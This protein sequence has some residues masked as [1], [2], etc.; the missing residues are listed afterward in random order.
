MQYP[1]QEPSAPTKAPNQDLK[2]MDALCT[3]KMKIENQNLE[4]GCIK[5]Q[6]PYPNGDHDAKPQSGTSNILQS[7]KS[8]LEGHSWSLHL[9]HQDREPIFGTMMYQ[10]LVIS[11]SNDLHP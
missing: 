8:G 4:Y 2:D 11:L 7:P 3:S 9:Q 1:G 6:W 5:D 10:R